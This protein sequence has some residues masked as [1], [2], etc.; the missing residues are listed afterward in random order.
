MLRAHV[1]VT[2]SFVAVALYNWLMLLP[3]YVTVSA[4]ISDSFSPTFTPSDPIDELTVAGLLL[5]YFANSVQ[6]TQNH[7]ETLSAPENMPKLANRRLVELEDL[8]LRDT[9]TGLPNRRAFDELAGQVLCASKFGK[10]AQGTLFPI[11]LDGFKLIND[12]YRLAAGDTLLK[13]VRR[14]LSI[15]LKGPDVVAQFGGDEFYI[16]WPGPLNCAEMNRI[17]DTSCAICANPC[18]MNATNC[19]SRAVSASRRHTP[20]PVSIS[21]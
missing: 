15:Y 17:S 4:I 9:L 6:T 10:V 7:K 8:S 18:A 20:V 13:E 3:S 1:H 14:W 21:C 2:N 11:D 12:S 5:V 19:R 16:D